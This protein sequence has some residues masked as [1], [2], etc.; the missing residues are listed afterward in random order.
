MLREKTPTASFEDIVIELLLQKMQGL[1]ILL[2][3]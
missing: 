2:D 3:S 1:P